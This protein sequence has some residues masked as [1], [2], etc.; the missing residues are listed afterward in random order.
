MITNSFYDNQSQDLIDTVLSIEDDLMNNLTRMIGTNDT[1]FNFIVELDK[2]DLIIKWRAEKLLEL[3]ELNEKNIKIIA[4]RMGIEVKQLK[5]IIE[6]ST[7]KL[8]QQEESTLSKAALIG[9][10]REASGLEQS[11]AIRNII[12]T[13]QDLSALSF[14]GL[15][16]SMLQSAGIKYRQIINEVATKV[17]V[18]I[19]TPQQAV[20]EAV[21]KFLS[22]GLTG[23]RD[24]AGKNWAPEAYANL[25]IRTNTKESAKQATFQRGKEYGN[26]H[27]EISSHA[28]AREKC[29][30][31][32]GQ[33]YSISNN[34]TSIQDINGNTLSVKAWSQTSNGQPDGILGINCTHQVYQ[35]VPGFSNKTFEKKD[36]GETKQGNMER[37]TQRYNER[38]IRKFKTLAQSH[39]NTGSVAATKAAK[40]KVAEWQKRQRVHINKTDRVR[41]YEKEQIRR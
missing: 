27:I 26:D 34:T 18:G 6:E 37:N 25:V 31:D 21:N 7:F 8:L 11:L 28:D 32:Q 5:K 15:N 9:I 30:I 20:A 12:K 1:L 16:N 24:K 41:H 40:A 22:N 14:N 33:L 17:L 38:Q 13:F 19:K 23:F 29:A 3:G 4:Q 39:E 35:F 36:L 2:T 10:L